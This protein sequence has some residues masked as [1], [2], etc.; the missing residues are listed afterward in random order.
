[1][2][3]RSDM[4]VILDTYESGKPFYLYTGRGPSSDAMHLGHLIP[5]LFTKY[6]QDAFNVPLVVQMT[7]D[8]KFL[9]KDMTFEQ[10][11]V[12]MLRVR[13]YDNRLGSICART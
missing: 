7:D 6:L 8:E 1:M 5:F 3:L 11:R 10:V 2:I 4:N 12:S 13:I 9:Y